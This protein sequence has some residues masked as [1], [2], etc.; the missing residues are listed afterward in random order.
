MK[1]KP[2]LGSKWIRKTYNNKE[3]NVTAGRIRRGKYPYTSH[4]FFVEYEAV[5]DTGNL[6]KKGACRIDVWLRYNKLDES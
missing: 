5:G 3:Y 4:N 6:F 1:H 2:K